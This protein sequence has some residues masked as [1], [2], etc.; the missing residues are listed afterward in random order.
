MFL[1]KYKSPLWWKGLET[2][3]KDGKNI[4][5]PINSKKMIK[6]IERNILT[7]MKAKNALDNLDIP[8]EIQQV[9]DEQLGNDETRKV[10]VPNLCMTAEN[11]QNMKASFSSQNIQETLGD[12]R[13]FFY[14]PVQR[15]HPSRSNART[16]AQTL[17]NTHTHTNNSKHT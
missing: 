11:M 12:K 3:I 10:I 4:C 15:H 17:S 5:G 16:H 14:T 9:I 8:V 13:C 1:Y 7:E 6:T 2:K